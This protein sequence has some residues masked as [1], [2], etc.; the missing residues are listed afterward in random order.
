MRLGPRRRLARSGCALG[1][2]GAL[3]LTSCAGHEDAPPPPKPAVLVAPVT[4]ETVPVTTEWVGTTSGSVN[5]EIRAKVQGYLLAQQ[6]RDGTIVKAGQLLY[7]LDPRQYQA[8]YDQAAS[9]LQRAKANLLRSQLNEQKYRPLVKQGA[10]S[11]REYDDTFQQMKADEAAVRAAQ[12]ALEAA[13]LNLDWTRIT[14]PIEGVVGISQAQVGNLIAPTT[15]MTTVSRVDPIKVYFPITEQE[16]LQ[17]IKGIEGFRQG[18]PGAAPALT[19]I[20][21]NGQVYPLPGKVSAVNRQIESQTGAVQIEAL[22]P[23][24]DRMLSPGQYAR[25]RA[26][27]TTVRDAPIVPQR[28]VQEVQGTYQIAVVKPDDTVEIRPVT[29]GPRHGSSWVIEKGVQAGDRVI[30]EGLQKV[31]SGT[32]VDPKPWVAGADDAAPAA[33]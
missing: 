32:A 20:L 27:T 9:D 18:D 10:V 5:A 8:D 22:F 3:G 31:R 15:L 2:A 17:F 12:A 7:Q 24:P 30:V 29:V 23:N 14:S 19:L 6:Y 26:V 13:K 16:Y 33:G 21:S 4:T 1:L 28:A 11:Q 25:I